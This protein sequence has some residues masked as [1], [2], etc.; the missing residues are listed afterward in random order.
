MLSYP[1]TSDQIYPVIPQNQRYLQGQSRHISSTPNVKITFV[2]MVLFLLIGSGVLAL[3]LA[4]WFDTLRL[5]QTGV[6]TEAT[7][8]DHR[9]VSAKSSTAY[10]LTYSFTAPVTGL[11]KKA[12]FSNEVEVTEETYAQQNI[13]SSIEI[14]YLPNDPTV[15]EIPNQTYP[16]AFPFAIVFFLIG[17]I[18]AVV[19]V[20]NLRLNRLLVRKGTL[21]TG[22]AVLAKPVIVGRGEGR[23]KLTYSFADPYGQTV[24]RTQSLKSNYYTQAI[25]QST[26]LGILYYDSRHFR[27]L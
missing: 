12:N 3:G 1:R 23:V 26:R 11:V 17:I 21:L 7:I 18:A 13:Q 6:R 19:G 16:I 24:T 5:E 27:L 14:I 15:S 25:N 20:W 9:T 8:T 22:Y 2:V 10:Y 4:T